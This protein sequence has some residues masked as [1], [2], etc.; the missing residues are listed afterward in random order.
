MIRRAVVQRDLFKT[1]TVLTILTILVFSAGCAS[2]LAKQEISDLQ[3]FP[4]DPNSYLASTT[5]RQRLISEEQQESS[6][7]EFLDRHFRA[8]HGQAPPKPTS[9]Q[10]WALD[11]ISK[12]EVFAENLQPL[13]VE[14]IQRLTSQVDRATYPSLSRR[15]ITI[16]NSNFRA[17]PTNSP[18]YVDPS[19]A[20]EGFPFDYLQHAAIPA[21]TPVLVTHQ[22]IDKA[23]LFAESDLVSGWIPTADL[24]WVDDTF[25]HTFENGHYVVPT[26]EKTAVIDRKGMFRFHVGIG[27]ILPLITTNVDNH[28]VLIAIA[29]K[30]RQAVLTEAFI[31]LEHASAFPLPLTA[32]H[33]SSLAERMMGQPYGWGDSFDGRDC[34]GTLR[35]LFFPFGLWLPRNSSKQALEG[36]VI[37]LQDLTPRQREQLLLETGVPYLTLVRIPGHIMLY[38][39][40]HHNRAAVLHTIWGLRTKNLTGREGRWVIGKTVIT[41]LEPGMEQNGISLEINNLLPRVESMNILNH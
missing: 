38:L 39:G 34:S 14:R 8:W 32:Q 23:W 28:Q 7:A 10:F 5:G 1:F 29:D 19:K 3:R 40:K 25:I 17:L 4:Q 24:A 41:G 15:A 11:W 31:P 20:G 18:L 2:N 6:A 16:N 9:G 13:S 37:S 21:N 26:L 36:D 30:D 35:D 12:Q 33:V 22:S 27:S